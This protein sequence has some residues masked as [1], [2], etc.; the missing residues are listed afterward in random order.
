MKYSEV[1]NRIVPPEKRDEEHANIW[2]NYVVR[3]L[4]VVFT[5]PL[6]D[7]DIEPIQVTKVSI[8]C[9]IIGFVLFSFSSNTTVKLIGI[10]L[11]FVWAILDGVDGNLARYNDLCSNLGDLW[12]TTGGYLAMILM[13]YS[14]GLACDKVHLPLFNIK[15]IIILA[16]F[17]A[18]FSIFPRL[19]MQKKLTYGGNEIGLLELKDKNTY[20]RKERVA[21]NAISPSGIYQ[22]I[23]LILF[24][25]GFLDYFVILYFIFYTLVMILSLRKLLS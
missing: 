8:A 2:V 23:L 5:I 17:T 18:I 1:Y 13:N 20:G 3:P 25:L 14:A 24:L 9:L 4:S 6:I 12:D 21:Q 19:I 15:S 10:S 7:R 11:Y 22:P 16:G